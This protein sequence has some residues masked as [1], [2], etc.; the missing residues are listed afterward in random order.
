MFLSVITAPILLALIINFLIRRCNVNGK[1]ILQIRSATPIQDMNMSAPIFKKVKK[2]AAL[3]LFV[4]TMPI[5]KAV[6]SGNGNIEFNREITRSNL[7]L[8][9]IATMA[10]RT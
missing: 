9:P 3:R 4:M 10:D 7:K 2:L 1:I 8:P 6:A 5:Q